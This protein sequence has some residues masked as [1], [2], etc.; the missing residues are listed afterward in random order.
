MTKLPELECQ[1]L[2][3]ARQPRVDADDAPALADE[4]PLA[5]GAGA[6]TQFVNRRGDKRTDDAA[7]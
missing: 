3:A 5:I 1:L 6:A 2:R 4:V 7:S